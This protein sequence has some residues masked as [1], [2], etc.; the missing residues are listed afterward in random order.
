MS[1][2]TIIAFIDKYFGYRKQIRSLENTIRIGGFLS[3]GD[4]PPIIQIINEGENLI[5][6]DIIDV[7]N[8][9]VVNKNA[10]QGW[11]P[12]YFDKGN[13]IF[14]PTLLPVSNMPEGSKFRIIVKNEYGNTFAS[15]IVI[16]KNQVKLNTPTIHCFRNQKRK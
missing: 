10:M 13:S 3:K 2:Q 12:L 1:I 7:D 5:V 4:N 16:N 11:F 15:E 14:I 8:K 6:Y 9:R